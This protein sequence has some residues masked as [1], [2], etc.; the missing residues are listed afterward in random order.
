MMI[1]IMDVIS[2]YS[3]AK[4][5]TKTQRPGSTAKLNCNR[6]R[7]VK[8]KHSWWK[9]GKEVKIAKRRKW[10]KKGMLL[11]KKFSSRDQGK[12]TCRDEKGKVIKTIQLLLQGKTTLEFL[13]SY[14]M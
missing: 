4:N 14:Y 3:N 9:D 7:G 6:V 2:D 11:I 8:I 1:N 12:Y 10:N 13:H 5:V